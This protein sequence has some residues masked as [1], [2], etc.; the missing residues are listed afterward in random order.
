MFKQRPEGGG[1]CITRQGK[2][3]S[4]LVKCSSTAHIF[5]MREEKRERAGETGRKREVLSEMRG[6]ARPDEKKSCGRSS[7]S[8]AEAAEIKR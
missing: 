5:E 1:V 8:K 6:T 2:D 4:I 3:R 7:S